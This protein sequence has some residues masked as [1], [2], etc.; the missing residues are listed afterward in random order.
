[1]RWVLAVSLAG[2]LSGCATTVASNDDAPSAAAAGRERRR[3]DIAR[4]KLRDAR[5]AERRHDYRTALAFYEEL[6]R[7]FRTYFE[8]DSAIDIGLRANRCRLDRGTDFVS[9]RAEMESLVGDAFRDKDLYRLKSFASCEFHG[10][11]AD[12]DHRVALD[13]DTAVPVLM[14]H[15]PERVLKEKAR[16]HPIDA[17]SEELTFWASNDEGVALSFSKMGDD[18]WAWT[19]FK[20]YDKALLKKA[21]DAK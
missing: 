7:G 10:A 8:D 16:V 1:M 5:A 19:G 12:S 9:S 20:T 15:V 13:S 18:E 11:L 2:A 4:I 21:K 17:D 6:D 14:A 3:A